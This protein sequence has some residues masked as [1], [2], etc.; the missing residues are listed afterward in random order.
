MIG[1]DDHSVSTSIYGI[2]PPDLRNGTFLI[3]PLSDA[4]L[5]LIVPLRGPKVVL[6]IIVFYHDGCDPV[7]VLTL[8]SEEL[9]A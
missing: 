8:P 9:D 1:T 3:R 2:R 5:A 7:P 4:N 6:L